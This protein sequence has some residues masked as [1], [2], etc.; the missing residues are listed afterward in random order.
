M[1]PVG[2]ADLQGGGPIEAASPA[3]EPEGSVPLGLGE[4]PCT[5]EENTE[6]PSPV[7]LNSTVIMAQTDTKSANQQPFVF[8]KVES[9]A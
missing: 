7:F 9:L 1:T 2:G 8:A 6:N 4:D 5:S 3:D